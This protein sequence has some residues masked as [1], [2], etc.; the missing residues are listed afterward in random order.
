MGPH[1]RAQGE[2]DKRKPSFRKETSRRVCWEF[3]Q[4]KYV[5]RSIFGHHAKV[6]CNKV[7]EA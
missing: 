3:N 1:A 6:A 5:S 7:S 4:A 2:V